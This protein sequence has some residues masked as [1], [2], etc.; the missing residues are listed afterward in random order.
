MNYEDKTKAVTGT[1]LVAR[2]LCLVAADLQVAFARPLSELEARK[3]GTKL[4]YPEN[5]IVLP[6]QSQSIS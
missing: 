3:P 4:K 1:V 6:A 5:C 2:E